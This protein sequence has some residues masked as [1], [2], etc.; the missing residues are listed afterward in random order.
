MKEIENDFDFLLNLDNSDG[1]D[2][3]A[4]VDQE[5]ESSD[6]KEKRNQKKVKVEIM[7]E[8]LNALKQQTRLHKF[9]LIEEYDFKRDTRIPDLKIELKPNTLVRDYQEQALSKMFSNG[10]ARS[11]IIVLPCGAGKTLTGIT[12]GCTIHKSILVVC[13]SQVSSEQWKREFLK[14][15]MINPQDIMIFTSQNSKKSENQK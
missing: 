8:S 6:K 10:R 15:S 3:L 11:G 14:W 1:D 5:D 9:P 7:P 4:E 2:D 13:T 12:A